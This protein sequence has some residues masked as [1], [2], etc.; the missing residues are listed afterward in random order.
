MSEYIVT[1]MARDRVGIVADVSGALFKL[2]GNITD[3]SQT[4]LRGYFTLIISVGTPDSVTADSIRSSVAAAGAA[5]EFDV[6]VKPYEPEPAQAPAETEL[7][8][9]TTRGRDRPGIIAR[10]TSYLAGQGINIED[11]YARVVSGDLLMIIQ[12]AVPTRL[13]IHDLQREIEQVGAEF[14]LTAHLQH[15]N[16]FRMTNELRP[17]RTTRAGRPTTDN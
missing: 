17:V 2:G 7:F 3:L 1:V 12:A 11:F 16:I 4:L 6:G 10:V 8:V 5:G 9:L 15:E 13:N 14:G